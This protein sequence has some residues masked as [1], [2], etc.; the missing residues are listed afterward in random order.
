VETAPTV[1]S[2]EEKHAPLPAMA[3][4]KTT[5]ISAFLK[6]LFMTTFDRPPSIHFLTLNSINGSHTFEISYRLETTRSRDA[7]DRIVSWR[8]RT[9]RFTNFL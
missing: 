2:A 8:S 6:F 7:L 5:P 3:K 4:L 1:R 9:P